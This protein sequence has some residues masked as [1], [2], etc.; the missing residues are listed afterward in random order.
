MGERLHRYCRTIFLVWLTAFFLLV[1]VCIRSTGWDVPAQAPQ[2]AETVPIAVKPAPQPAPEPQPAPA[3][4]PEPLAIGSIPGEGTLGKPECSGDKL[5]QEIRIPYTGQ[6]GEY[7]TFS[8]HNVA[9]RSFDI[10]GNW[11]FADIKRQYINQPG[12]PIK[13]FQMALHDGFVRLSLIFH[14][15]YSH[16]V[17]AFKTRDHILIRLTGVKAENEPK[18]TEPER[19]KSAAKSRKTP[20]QQPA[21]TNAKASDTAPAAQKP[22]KSDPGTSGTAPAAQKPVRGTTNQLI[23]IESMSGRGQ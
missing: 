1:F 10:Q 2:P 21:Q 8:P 18:S 5:V 17:E 16:K 11:K 3:P 14:G 6:L 19:Q 4:G 9:S 20:A 7:R 12:Y 13:L 22:V 23:K 15:N